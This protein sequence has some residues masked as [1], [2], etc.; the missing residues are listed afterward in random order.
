MPESRILYEGNEISIALRDNPPKPLLLHPPASAVL[1][2]EKGLFQEYAWFVEQTRAG[3]NCRSLEIPAGKCKPDENSEDCAR[4]ELKEET[5]II[6]GPLKELVSYYPAIGLSTE[7]LT[8][9]KAKALNRGETD[10]DSDEDIKVIR[11][12]RREYRKLL[13]QKKIT[14]AKTILIAQYW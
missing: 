3:C 1:A 2:I 5:G 12:S 8:I 11:L 13:K 10:F 6:A 9:F 4:R 14:D 7:L